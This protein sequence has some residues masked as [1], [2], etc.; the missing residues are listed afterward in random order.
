MFRRQ[1]LPE[2][3]FQTK[4]YGSQVVPSETPGILQKGINLFTGCKQNWISV[5]FMLKKEMGLKSNS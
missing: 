1:T 3:E 2:A 5:P 4:L